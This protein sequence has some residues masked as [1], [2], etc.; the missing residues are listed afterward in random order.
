MCNSK[1]K[2]PF[3][4]YSVVQLK[5]QFHATDGQ[6]VLLAKGARNVG[7]GKHLPWGRGDVPLTLLQS[8]LT[9]NPTGNNTEKISESVSIQGLDSHARHSS[10]QENE[11]GNV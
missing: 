6:A 9:V 2:L 7:Q 1:L 5:R 3:S 8:E 10:I 11:L 4:L